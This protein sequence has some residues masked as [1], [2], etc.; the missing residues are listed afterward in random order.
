MTD[1]RPSLAD[2][3]RPDDPRPT[4]AG[5][6][7]DTP[8]ANDRF[9]RRWDSWFWLSTTAAVAVHFAVFALWP[10]MAVAVDEPAER[11]ASI[12]IDVLPRFE[13]PEA[14]TDVRQPQIPVLGV[15]R[16]AIDAPVEMDPIDPP[17]F[18]DVIGPP[19]PTAP[20]ADRVDARFTPYEVGPVLRN[21]SEIVRT[22]QREYPP[23]LKESEIGGVVVVWAFVGVDG[24]VQEA[25]V[26]ESSGYESMDAAALRVAGE[27]EFRPALNR[28]RK[29]A[30]WVS[31]PI[32]FR[33]GRV[34]GP[35]ATG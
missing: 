21:E 31:F 29:V 24:A 11:R 23:L 35:V 34:P 26:R 1:A 27:M 30:V 33:V 16:V 2:D 17:D 18:A 4:L 7:P 3:A 6:V 19:P 12:A 28:D 25:E 13:M 5:A 8:I 32:T 15:P 22:L 20:P 10:D 14:P 9:K